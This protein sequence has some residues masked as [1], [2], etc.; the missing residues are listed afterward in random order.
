MK[1][2][3]IV[4]HCKAEGQAADAPLTAEGVRQAEKLAEFFSDKPIDYIVSSPFDRAYRTVKPLADR[5]GLEIAMDERLT[6]RIL[7]GGN[8]PDWREL[9]RNTF[10]DLDL[11]YVGGEAS[12]TAMGRAVSAVT[13]VL[14]SGYKNVVIVTHGNLMSLLLK[15]YDSRIGFAEWEALS[16]PDVYRLS[17]VEDI[18]SIHR[19]WMDI[20]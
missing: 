4:R 11:R 20:H 9:L 15:Y 14:N 3:Y 10:D 19:V 2:V 12:S 16:N 8:R 18:P 7:S 6:E 13:E 5:L 1:H 17:F